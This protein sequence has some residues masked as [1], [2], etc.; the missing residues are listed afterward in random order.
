MDAHVFLSAQLW[1][2]RR[3]P[4]AWP[5]AEAND[6][7]TSPPAAASTT[8]TLST[9]GNAPSAEKV[10]SRTNKEVDRGTRIILRGA[11][12]CFLAEDSMN[13]SSTMAAYSSGKNDELGFISSR[14]RPLVFSHRRAE[15]K[16][17]QGHRD[18]HR[19]AKGHNGGLQAED[20]SSVP[21]Q[22]VRRRGQDNL[23][24]CFEDNR[25][26]NNR[27]GIGH[28]NGQGGSADGMV[29]MPSSPTC[30]EVTGGVSVKSSFKFGLAISTGTDFQPA[31]PAAQK[32]TGRDIEHE[33]GVRA[34]GHQGGEERRRCAP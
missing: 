13:A 2:H 32:G 11:R 14:E 21:G 10:T 5:G 12:C 34:D 20:T 16:P 31:I 22:E 23:S 1:L 29:A 19:C 15:I 24:Y 18:R 28:A 7:R 26:G 27:Y 17:G 30:S 8:T 4:D 9:V 3:P 25:S 33:A 6:A